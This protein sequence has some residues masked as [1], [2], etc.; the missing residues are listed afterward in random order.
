MPMTDKFP[1]E[2]K[3]G[4][5]VVTASRTYYLFSINEQIKAEFMYAFSS[6]KN[7]KAKPSF[8]FYQEMYISL[9]RPDL[10]KLR[11]GESEEKKENPN[12]QQEIAKT[13][14]S[15]EK[16]MN[17][18]QEDAKKAQNNTPQ[19]EPEKPTEN[20]TNHQ[21]NN[22]N[23]NEN[24]KKEENP[25]S[26]DIADIIKKQEEAKKEPKPFE[27][28]KQPKVEKTVELTK[29]EEN[30]KEN[31]ENEDSDHFEQEAVPE[32]VDFDRKTPTKDIPPENSKLNDKQIVLEKQAKPLVLPTFSALPPMPKV[33]AKNKVK[34][35]EGQASHDIIEKPKE[36]PIPKERKSI[37]PQQ[38]KIQRE[39][40]NEVPSLRKNNSND[41][42][43]DL[44]P[45]E[46]NIE[47]RQIQ[48]A[49]TK[50]IN[51]NKDLDENESDEFQKFL[52]RNSMAATHSHFAKQVEEAVQK[53]SWE[54]YNEPKKQ[55][56]IPESKKEET[57]KISPQSVK[58]GSSDP[59]PF[60]E[61]WD[62]EE[63][64][65]QKKSQKIV[66]PPKPKIENKPAK[67]IEPE[68]PKPEKKIE[69]KP[70]PKAKKQEEFEENW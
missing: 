12:F 34:I 61:E 70:K 47:D 2:T 38:I 16:M 58:S 13:C 62:S 50:P 39:G 43:K 40:S 11:D 49:Q 25:V 64:A 5:T 55:H 42:K 24:T 56:S 31:E 36:K 32:V 48:R 33:P 30:K 69:E 52:K 54:G 65:P 63:T 7:L 8:G 53:T 22:N 41:I 67:I 57:K 28:E 66:P 46:A 1:S 18:I 15:V 27:P 6:L 14:K 51:N 68:I 4:F 60:E 59:D 20:P 3:I 35:V 21:E 10:A 37:Q 45:F 17:I 9:F 29:N 44:G 23:K 19:K 26:P